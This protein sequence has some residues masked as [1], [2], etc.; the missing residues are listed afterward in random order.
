MFIFSRQ[1]EAG[2]LTPKQE[3]LDKCVRETNAMPEDKVMELV[4][5]HFDRAYTAFHSYRTLA[6]AFAK[7][8]RTTMIDPTAFFAH[9][10]LEDSA[11]E[12]STIIAADDE[13]DK[14]NDVDYIPQLDRGHPWCH[15]SKKAS[16]GE[17]KIETEIAPMGP[18]TE[19]IETS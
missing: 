11:P 8:R 7:N 3:Q 2:D 5:I 13:E 16:E 12:G 1:G 14:P 19:E 9:A 15:D 4:Q 17:T 6:D 18:D 10:I